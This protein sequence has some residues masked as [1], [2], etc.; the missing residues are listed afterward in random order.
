MIF[1]KIHKIKANKLIIK[2][3]NKILNLIKINQ[4]ITKTIIN[5]KLNKIHK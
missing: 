4:K 3:N 1:N 5:K 2:Y